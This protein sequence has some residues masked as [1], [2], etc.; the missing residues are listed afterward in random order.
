MTE[1][2]KYKHNVSV[3]EVFN[4]LTIVSNYK[5]NRWNCICQCGK[6]CIF[7]AVDL[8][9]KHD[10]SC[11]CLRNFHGMRYHPAYKSWLHMK[12]RCNNPKNQDYHN[13]GGRGITVHE[14]FQKSFP[15]FLS[16]IGERPEGRWSIGRIDNNGHYTYGN[17][18]WET[19]SQ[20]ARNHCISRVN[21]SG[22]VGVLRRSRMREGKEYCAWI[23]SWY[24][25]FKKYSKEFSC[26]KYGEDVAK[27]LAIDYRN[28]MIEELKS[29][30]FDYA[31]SHG[32]EKVNLNDKNK[33]EEASIWPS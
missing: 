28:E 23:A 2:R 15:T 9:T 22:I 3:G 24:C 7:D 12:Q 10:T 31:D 29:Q 13:Y 6:E 4:K 33:R 25:E 32:T 11:G 30:G 18:R 26:N 21:T 14:D 1:V 20:Q 5:G 19:D 16:E 17:I 8:V 27:Q